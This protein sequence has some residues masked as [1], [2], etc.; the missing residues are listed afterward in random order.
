MYS[1]N[2]ENMHYGTPVN[3][4]APDRIPGGSSSGSAVAVA[5]GLS[6]FAL[7]TDTGGSVRVP[8][9]YCGIFGFRPTHN[10]VLIDGVIP[11]A[12]SFDTVGWMA[13]S[14]TTLLEVG[15]A[16][17]GGLDAESPS[18][19]RLL[20]A[21]DAW[22]IA[23]PACREALERFARPLELAAEHV[24]K[25]T[26]SS[27]GLKEWHQAFRTAQGLD[28]WRTHGEWIEREKPVFEESIGERFAWA[29][30]LDE[31]ESEPLLKLWSEVRTRLRE[32]LG[33]DGLLVIPTIPGTAPERGIS[34]EAN[35]LRRVHTMQLS[36]IAGLS[37]LPQLTIPAGT[38]DGA[39]IGLS[40]IAGAKQDLKLLHWVNG[41][42]KK[43]HA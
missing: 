10:Y 2:G 6:E 24:E 13:R 4:A 15:K 23:E 28:I 39:P 22:A 32:L 31:A 18:F 25:V 17:L 27:E 38:V 29:S 37:G 40:I 20:F 30:T 42:I 43:L 33:E 34:G 16:L 11:L 8:S 12:P 3:P 5:A 41:Q 35:E 36:C 21:K 1:L 19:S 7:G 9:A 14:T 26:I